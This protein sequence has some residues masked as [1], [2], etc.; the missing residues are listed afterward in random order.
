LLAAAFV[1]VAAW[2][3]TANMGAAVGLIIDGF[4][5]F[6]SPMYPAVGWACFGL[7]LGVAWALVQLGRRYRA[8]TFLLVG[9]GGLLLLFAVAASGAAKMAQHFSSRKAEPTAV[10]ACSSG[11]PATITG[12]A[13]NIRLKPNATAAVVTRLN[14]RTAVR[15]IGRSPGWILV[16]RAEDSV[17]LGW[18][19][20]RL[21]A[22]D[23]H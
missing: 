21:T 22:S 2:T 18:V 1:L 7:V 15:V 20:E 10:S 14:R 6:V 13:V 12:D 19:T 5:A 9:S 8:K 23:S 17:P 3:I 4:A 11:S 16:C